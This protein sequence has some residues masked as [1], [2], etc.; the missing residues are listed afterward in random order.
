MSL[1]NPKFTHSVLIEFKYG[2]KSLDP[3]LDLEDELRRILDET[4]IG[5]HDG[6]EI[7]MD[8]SDGKIF[9]F[10]TNAEAVYKLIEPI[11][12]S[13]DWMDGAKVLL[14]FGDEADKSAKEIDFTLASV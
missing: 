6:H 13:V 2:M 3:L 8:D 9:L 10:G 1:I 14:R 5:Y 4:D 11:L 7:A 12:F